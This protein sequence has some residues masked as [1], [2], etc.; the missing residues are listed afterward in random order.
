MIVSHHGVVTVDDLFAT[1]RAAYERAELEGVED[2]RFLVDFRRCDFALDKHDTDLHVQ[3]MNAEDY[4]T[5]IPGLRVAMI[6]EDPHLTA[7]GLLFD[8][9]ALKPGLRV[10]STAEGAWSFL[11]LELSSLAENADL[12]PTVLPTVR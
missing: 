11:D 4:W 12:V 2:V 5:R 1:D 3:R 10:F 6:T 8:L 9:K 7:L